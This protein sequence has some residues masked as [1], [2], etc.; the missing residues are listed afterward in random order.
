MS[1]CLLQTPP[2]LTNLAETKKARESSK[3]AGG[4]AYQED[5]APVAAEPEQVERLLERVGERRQQPRRLRRRRRRRRLR[6]EL[7]GLP[8]E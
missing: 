3:R 1:P 8:G 6:E 5:P 7:I 4:V 2:S